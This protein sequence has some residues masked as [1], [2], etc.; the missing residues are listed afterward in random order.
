M[1][2]Y[3]NFNKLLLTVFYILQQSTNLMNQL[4]IFRDENEDN[5]FGRLTVSYFYGF[6]IFKDN[7]LFLAPVSLGI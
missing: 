5:V 2:I 4:F 3:T 7:Y 1:N 6:L